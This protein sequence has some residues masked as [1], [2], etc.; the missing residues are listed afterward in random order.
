MILEPLRLRAFIL[1]PEVARDRIHADFERMTLAVLA[2]G[3]DA[4]SVGG[5][6]GADPCR[7]GE[8]AG[9]NRMRY[10][11]GNFPTFLAGQL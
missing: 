2:V 4:Q 3:Q 9:C 7:D 6:C 1:D 8:E 5:V 11:R 10:G